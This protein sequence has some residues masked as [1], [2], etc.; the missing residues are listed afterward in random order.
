MLVGLSA[1][2]ARSRPTPDLLMVTATTSS[3]AMPRSACSISC[4]GYRRV[5]PRGLVIRGRAG[6][7]G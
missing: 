6:A 3:G 7:L 2:Y 1:W 5:T 4:W